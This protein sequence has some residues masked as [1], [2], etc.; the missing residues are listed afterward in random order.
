[1]ICGFSRGSII[2]LKISN[3]EKVYAW[4]SPHREAVK[5]IVELNHKGHYLSYCDENVLCLWGFSKNDDK[6][7]MFQ[8]FNTLW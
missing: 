7:S 4:F 3:L 8:V 6:I 2:F 1:M 5:C